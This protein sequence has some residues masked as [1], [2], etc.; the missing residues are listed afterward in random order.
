MSKVLTIWKK[1]ALGYATGLRAYVMVALMLGLS[2]AWFSAILA[3]TRESSLRN[4]ISLDVS[5]L[6]AVTPMLTMRSLAEENSR[7][8]LELLLTSP[9]TEWD[10]VLGKFL[11]ALTPLLALYGVLLIFPAVLWKVGEPQWGPM[12]SQFALLLG[13]SCA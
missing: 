3:F 6:L 11:G 7:G 4:V 8:T 13:T 5:I 1:E 9:V 10:V 2:A 12:L